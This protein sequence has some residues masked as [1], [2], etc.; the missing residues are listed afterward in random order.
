MIPEWLQS[1]WPNLLSALGATGLR[2]ALTLLL[3]LGLGLGGAA[4]MRISPMAEARLTG[5][6]LG[7]SAIPWLLI[8]VTLNM[9]PSVGLRDWTAILLSALATAVPL[10]SLG[11]RRLEQSRASFLRRGLWS[12]FTAVVVSELLSRTDG[13][14]AMIRYYALFTRYERLALYIGCAL[15]V[16]VLY[17]LLAR[18]LERLLTGSVLWTPGRP[19]QKTGAARG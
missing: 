5:L 15:L 2:L 14:G 1:E 8:M 3:G 16:F 9:V 10:L 4:L 17:A 11:R 13:L 19:L 18:L 12:G 7:L 6:V